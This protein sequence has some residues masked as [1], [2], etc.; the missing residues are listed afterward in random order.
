MLVIDTC[1]WLKIRRLEQERVLI[2][3]DLFKEAN[4]H[5]THELAREYK[6]YLNDYLDE[7]IFTINPVRLEFFREFT[8]KQ[9]DDADLSIIALARGSENAIV[10]SDDGAELEILHFFHV[11]A[12]KLSDYMLWLVEHGVIRKNT[13]NRV[14]KRLREWKNIGEHATRRVLAEINQA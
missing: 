11:N 9:L 12:F 5:A 4:L 14:V 3:M 6:H 10:I 13:A 1:S 2:L 7:S 8:G